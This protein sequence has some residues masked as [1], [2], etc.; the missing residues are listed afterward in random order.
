MEHPSNSLEQVSA[1]ALILEAAS[2]HL[3]VVVTPSRVDLPEGAY[4]NVDGVAH[5]PPTFVEVYAHQGLLRGGQR[6]KIAG[7]VLKLLTLGK[8]HPGAR[9]VLAF[10]DSDVARQVQN[11]GWLAEAIRTW[12]VRVFVADLPDNVRAGLKAA[13]GRQIMV[14]PAIEEPGA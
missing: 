6:H 1:E 12:G 8:A 2:I 14:N 4:V 13:Q 10:A 9:L 5:E 11:K 7:D 3:G